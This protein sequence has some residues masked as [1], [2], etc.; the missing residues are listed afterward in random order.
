MSKISACLVVYNEEAKIKKCLQSLKDAVDEIIVVHDGEC[1]DNTLK[2]CYDYGAKVFTCFHAGFMEAHLPFCFSNAKGDWLL[3]I[4]ADEYLSE[5]L[6]NNLRALTEAEGVDAYKFL[7]PIYD[8]KRFVTSGWP[9]KLC[10]F[11]RD[12]VSFLG[13]IHYLPEI[14][15][16][17][18]KCDYKLIHQPDYNNFSW[19]C[20][21]GKWIKWAK[22]QAGNYFKEFNQIAKFNYLKNDWP[23][24]I[25]LRKKYPIMLMPFEFFSTFIKDLILGGYKEFFIGYKSALMYACYRIMVNYYIF[26]KK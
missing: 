13:V 20:F 21:K 23:S 15:G 9:Y 4:D 19:T 3:R 12:K 26:L 5:R 10:F 8:G 17:I 16:H 14:N 11:K 2:I 18:R 25:K 6:K 1:R 24:K 22:I 7:W